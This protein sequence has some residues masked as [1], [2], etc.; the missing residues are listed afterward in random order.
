MPILP[1]L[2]L[3]HI[4]LHLNHLIIVAD[5]A[6]VCRVAWLVVFVPALWLP[7]LLR[8]WPCSALPQGDVHSGSMSVTFGVLPL[9]LLLLLLLP[10]LIVLLLLLLERRTQHRDTCT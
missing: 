10:L 7:L 6:L 3:P 5:F 1:T 9:L 4:P 2:P 8:L